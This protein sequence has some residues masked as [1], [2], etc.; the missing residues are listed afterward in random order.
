MQK[1]RRPYLG[2]QR[3]RLRGITQVAGMPCDAVV[4][5]TLTRPV[6]RV[7]FAIFA[8]QAAQTMR[9]DEA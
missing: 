1:V 8:Q 5:V 7:N 4:V 6:D 3:D 9:P 2:N